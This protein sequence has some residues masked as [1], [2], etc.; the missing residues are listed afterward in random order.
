[1]TG[2]VVSRETNDGD[3]AQSKW[4]QPEILRHV[5]HAIKGRLS[6]RGSFAASIGE[7]SK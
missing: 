6:L 3:A 2:D 5:C 4:R 7:P 1:M